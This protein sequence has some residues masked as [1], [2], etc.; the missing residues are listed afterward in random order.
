MLMSLPFLQL[1]FLFLHPSMTMCL[2]LLEMLSVYSLS[3]AQPKIK[4][5]W[6]QF[7]PKSDFTWK[8]GS[9]LSNLSFAKFSLFCC[10]YCCCCCC[11][12]KL[13]RKRKTVFYLWRYN[14]L[15]F[16]FVFKCFD[17]KE[18][19]EKQLQKLFLQ[20]ETNKNNNIK[21]LQ[22]NKRNIKR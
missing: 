19:V 17:N 16:Y 22:N 14:L 3:C 18:S 4:L 5:R 1:F 13:V 21:K 9:N 8:I 10:C 12:I 6:S 15:I 20:L 7:F 2:H 11:S